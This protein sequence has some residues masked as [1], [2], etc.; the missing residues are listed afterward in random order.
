MQSKW[1]TRILLMPATV[2][3]LVMLILPLIVVFVFSFGE[4][5]P[6]GGYVPAFTLE[7]YSNLPARLTAFY[8][9]LLMAPIGTLLCLLVAYPLAYFLAVKVDPTPSSAIFSSKA[10]MVCSR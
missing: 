7:Q 10:R 3:L 1:N 9:T 5:G 2:L 8:N 6:A 4:R